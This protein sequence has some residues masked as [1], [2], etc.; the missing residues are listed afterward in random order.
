MLKAEAPDGAAGVA[1]GLGGPARSYPSML[2][3]AIATSPRMT[4]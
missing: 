4:G 3:P 1:R 2:S